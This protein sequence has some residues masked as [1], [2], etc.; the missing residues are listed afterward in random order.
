MQLYENYALILYKY[1]EKKKNEFSFPF[2]I[3]FKKKTIT[4]YSKKKHDLIRI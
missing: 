4:I 3:L 2:N 1:N